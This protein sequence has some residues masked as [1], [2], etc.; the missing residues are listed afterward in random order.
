MCITLLV[1]LYIQVSKTV[2]R[3]NGNY[4]ILNINIKT[5][6]ITKHFQEYSLF[7]CLKIEM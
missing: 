3:Y 4:M 1:P 7:V 6:K 2:G 5:L